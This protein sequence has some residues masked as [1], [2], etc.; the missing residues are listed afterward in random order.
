M[1]ATKFVVN[2]EAQHE[3]DGRKREIQKDKRDRE[4]R[5][6]K[7]CSETDKELAHREK[8]TDT[9]HGHAGRGIPH[10]EYR[11]SPKD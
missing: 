1:C 3:R 7:G 5:G 9:T 10:G 11:K 6:R 2:P 4:R 8:Q